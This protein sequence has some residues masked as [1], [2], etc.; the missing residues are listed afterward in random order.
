MYRLFIAID[1]PEEIKNGLS[2]LCY[3][4]PGAKWVD[5]NQVH[6]TLRFIGEVDGGIFRDIRS[7]LAEV[8]SE[9]FSLL[10]KDWGA[11]RL[12]RPHGSYGLVWKSLT[13]C[14]H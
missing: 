5:I 4:L 1:F 6:L 8:D 7:V 2:S 13:R 12:A 3:G 11:F 14:C 10:V 9:E